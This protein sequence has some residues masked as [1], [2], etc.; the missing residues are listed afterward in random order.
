MAQIGK[1]SVAFTAS[2][3]ELASGVASAGRA[4]KSLGGD[5]TVL[6]KAL[7]TLKATG[8]QS[9]ADIGPAAT[10]AAAAF[11]NT[12][13]AAASLA[14]QFRGG[15]I[16]A[17]QFRDSMGQLVE[18]A[19]RQADLFTRGAQVA[20]QNT[21]AQETYARAVDDLNAMLQAGAISQGVYEQALAKQQA[22]LAQADGSAAAAAAAQQQLD[23]AMREGASITQSVQTA[24]ERYAATIA[25]LDS[26]LAAGAITQEIYARAQA[27][28]AASLAQADGTAAA[29]AQAEAELNAVRQRAASITSSVMTAQERYQTALGE[30]NTLLAS[31]AINQETYA[32]AVQA[33]NTALAQA[34]G[35]AAAAAAAEQQLN[36]ARQRGASVTQS[37][38]TAQERY[39]ADLA[40]LNTLLRSGAISQQTYQR[41]VDAAAAKM[42]EGGT[43]AKTMESG[44][45]GI[46]SRLNILI[47]LNVASIFARMTQSIVQ[48]GQSLVRFAGQEAEAIDRTGKLAERLGFTYGEFAGLTHA[49]ELSG[50]PMDAVGKAA[51]KLDVA[52][53]KAAQ[54]S[55]QA[56]KAFANVGLTI[57]QLNG[58]NPAERFQAVTDA[59]AK[60]P[61][62]AE[63]S[64]AAIA[65]FGKQGAELVPLFNQGAGAIQAATAEA[66]RFGLALTEMQRQDVE[67]MNDAFTNAYEAIRGVVQQIVARLAPAVQSVTEAFT[68]L[69]SGVGGK[70]IGAAIA[71]ALLEG[72]RYLAGVADFFI[73]NVPRVWEYVAKVAD[74]WSVVWSVGQRIADALSGVARLFEAAFKTVGSI[75]TGIVGRLLNAI[76]EVA[77][78]IPGFGKV[79]ADI[80]KSGEWLMGQSKKM[81]S[82][83]GDALAKSGENFWNAAAGRPAEDT[84]KAIAGPV[85]TALD[86][87]IAKANESA[88]AIDAAKPAA[89]I[90]VKQKIDASGLKEAVKGIDSRSA[91]GI[92]EMFRLM[93]GDTGNNVQEQQLGV[94]EQI[95]EG[96]QEM[97]AGGLDLDVADFA[98]AAGV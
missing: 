1:V 95:N 86:A 93:R 26:L 72:A 64:A 78:T 50:V 94:L 47:G 42:R 44:L 80:E 90:E 37:V 24:Q 59:I 3:G 28:A 60:L 52:F 81:W 85:L 48:A 22:T 74:R 67:G 5:T 71:D 10:A 53:V 49:A 55:A 27:Q 65:L 92:K 23:A 7:S 19:A 51:T 77:K 8:A 73:A 75:L 13:E 98:P 88:A 20:A 31:G 57:E 25:N 40:D 79:G 96:I 4:F 15:Q 91:D 45:S 16:S 58:M 82:E 41:A 54:G 29:A 89:N 18:S 62:E 56:Q 35:T 21:T 6:S 43:A 30:L 17:D 46:S 63:R 66:D 97:N 61:T 33:Q 32:R 69:I 36:A 34:D 68:T 39:R 83:A 11:A 70:Q 87:A 9:I 84:G 38:M 12:Q 2:T 76:G 14:A